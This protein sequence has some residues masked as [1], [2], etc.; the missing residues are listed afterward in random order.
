[1]NSFNRANV[2]QMQKQI[3]AVLNEHGFDNVE[4]K[5]NGGARFGSTECTFKVQAKITGTQTRDESALETMA[6][7]HGID[8]ITKVG[9]KGETLI[10]FHSRKPKYPFIYT[11][12]RGARYKC[13]P[14]QAVRMFA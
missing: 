1:M 10:E 8:D 11:T 14:A 13:S 2:R 7:L 5:D 4:F 12:R 9:P 3:A 6:K